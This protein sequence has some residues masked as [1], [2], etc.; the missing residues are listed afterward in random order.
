[1]WVGVC[2]CVC[3][4]GVCV[5]G[6]GELQ[7]ITCDRYLTLASAHRL[8]HVAGA[9]DIDLDLGAWSREQ[10]LE[11]GGVDALALGAQHVMHH[12]L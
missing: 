6:A 4:G 7:H 9:A 11:R 1:M 10:L 12:E 3:G 5:G 2:V 8:G